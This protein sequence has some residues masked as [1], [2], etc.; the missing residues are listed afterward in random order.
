MNP[1]AAVE[2]LAEGGSKL[3]TRVLVSP[4]ANGGYTYKLEAKF[5]VSIGTVFRVACRLENGGVLYSG[6][7][8][9]TEF[10]QEETF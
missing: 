8:T 5:N 3:Q 7:R 6:L 10:P 4:G 1:V 2:L 9:A